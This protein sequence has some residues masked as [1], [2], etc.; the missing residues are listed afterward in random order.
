M[1]LR[2]RELDPRPGFGNF[3]KPSPEPRRF[4]LKARDACSGRIAPEGRRATPAPEVSAFTAQEGSCQ[5]LSTTF[6][7]FVYL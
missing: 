2:V 3:R 6:V 5:T 4:S 1:G 7:M